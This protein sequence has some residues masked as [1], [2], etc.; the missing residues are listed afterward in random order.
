MMRSN[1][2]DSDRWQRIPPVQKGLIPSPQTPA[3]NVHK[4]EHRYEVGKVS[5][6]E[7]IK[8]RQIKGILNKLTP[9][10]FDK[11]FGKV[12]DVQIQSAVTL[13][14]VISQI[15]DK[16]LTEPTF[17][18]M[19]AKFCKELAS[20]LPEF[21][22][23]DE[24]IT[25]KR[26]L[27]NKCQEAFERGEREE[28][29]AA[30]EGNGK[31]MTAEERE[32]KRIEAKKR[33][34]GN[35]RFI[36][37]LY[38][39]HMLTE[40]IMHGCIVKLLGEINNPEEEDIEA[41]CK[42]VSTIGHMIDQEKAKHHMDAYF[43]RMELL[44]SN[45]KL[46]SRIRFMLKDVIDL[47]LND[48]QV[49]RKVDGPKKIE[50]VHKDAVQERQATVAQ[51]GRFSRAASVVI[52]SGRR[53]A[54]V[55]DSGMRGSSSHLFSPT[56][57]IGGAQSG[58]LKGP[59]PPT[60]GRGTFVQDVRVEERL[61]PD[62]R[63]APIPLAQR[64]VDDAPITLGPQGGL[65][66]GPWRSA[67]ASK[68]AYN[69]SASSGSERPGTPPERPEKYGILNR[70]DKFV[71]SSSDRHPVILERTLSDKAVSTPASLPTHHQQQASKASGAPL[72]MPVDE[73]HLKEQSKSALV[74]YFRFV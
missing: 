25:F 35:I 21:V 2:A 38:K 64:S 32:A 33:M 55:S 61:F 65:G 20:A 53:T 66:R 10:N 28:A 1:T 50:E 70:P 34:L 46:S 31:E 15:F 40:R 51:A 9:Q 14:G 12:K 72:F 4:A 54:P 37:E 69:S 18:E 5:D 22:Q 59:Q 68:P 63:P 26:V 48:W 58:G 6:E 67:S 71:S 39:K 27:L 19:Y 8:Q 57:P 44:S 24:K 36:G 45:L 56:T 29:E 17:C 41:L 16:A 42:L 73:N 62:N 3:P 23:D 47:R 60:S 7:E 43:D 49:R 52:S 30:E 13:N 74:E 11:L